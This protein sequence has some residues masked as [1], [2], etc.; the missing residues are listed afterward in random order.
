[1]NIDNITFEN[2]D[3]PKDIA[4]KTV[5]IFAGSS[6]LKVHLSRLNVEYVKV[7][8]G[9]KTVYILRSNNFPRTEV[10]L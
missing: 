7:H 3:T 8:R 4:V 10:T 2:I 9:V 5:K 6:Q 1:M